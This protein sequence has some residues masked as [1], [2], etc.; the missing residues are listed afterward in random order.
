ML[1]PIKGTIER[2]IHTM[3][4]NADSVLVMTSLLHGS[5][6]HSLVATPTEQST[7]DLNHYL[8]GRL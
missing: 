4:L 8:Q 1:V 2:F 6:L 5:L 7:L 3:V